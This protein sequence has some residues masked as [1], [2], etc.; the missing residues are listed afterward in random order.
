MYIVVVIL[1]TLISS[2]LFVSSHDV[3]TLYILY[4]H[5][6]TYPW[7]C[8]FFR[9]KVKSDPHV[10]WLLAHDLASSLPH[11]LMM[12]SMIHTISLCMS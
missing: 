6:N 3:A 9:V 5:S 2:C 8:A 11:A 12:T 10:F 1:K 4:Y 7:S